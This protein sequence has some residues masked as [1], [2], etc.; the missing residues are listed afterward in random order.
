[1]ERIDIEKYLS[2]FM[3]LRMQC[4]KIFLIN[5]MRRIIIN[6]VEDLNINLC[7]NWLG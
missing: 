4:H 2:F 7:Y 1:M 5:Y 6:N 3:I